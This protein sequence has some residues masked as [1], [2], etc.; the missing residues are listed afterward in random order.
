M[1]NVLAPSSEIPS[2]V[3]ILVALVQ[4]LALLLLHQSTELQFWPHNELQW[5]FSFYSIS[6]VTPT[7]LLLGLSCGSEKTVYKWTFIFSLAVLATGFYIG[8]QAVPMEHVRY[9]ELLFIFVLTLLV[10]TFKGLMYVQHFATGA[11]L[12]YSRLF[13]LSW[14]NFLT[15]ALSLLFTLCFW[16][17]L[18]LWA[19]LFKAIKIDFFFDLFMERWFFYPALALANGFGVIIFRQQSNIIDTITRIQQALMKFLLV[20]LVFVSLIFLVTL[21]FTGLE[22]LWETGGSMLIL[23]MQALMLFFLNAVYQ[24]D[25]ESNP[26]PLAVHRFIYLGI[27]LLPIYSSISFYGLSLRVEQYGWSISRSWAFLLWTVFALF[28]LGYL[29]GILK[30]KDRWLHQLSWVNVR[31]GLVVLAL[32]FLVNTPVLDFRKLSLNSQLARLDSGVVSADEFD[33]SYLRNDLAKPGYVALEALK[34]KHGSSNPEIVVLINSLYANRATDGIGSSEE[35]LLSAIE[36]IGGELP[37]GLGSAVYS[38]L[39]DNPWRLNQNHGYYIFSVDLNDDSSQ[40]YVLLEERKGW[41]QLTL[42][43]RD[44]DAW[45]NANMS[46]QGGFEGLSEEVLSAIKKA[47]FEIRKSHWND[48]E[49][50]GVI[51]KVRQ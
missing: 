13:Q 23:W 38:L 39:S 42:F 34:E 26:Y 8:N 1:G 4:G 10:T 18:M 29:C 46:S 17:V 51:F 25:P 20:I 9:S 22:P 48:I 21:P 12:S 24:D 5:L 40:E 50:G 44:D 37:D 45:A 19:A 41:H 30:L 32:M 36:V 11:V 43:Y 16:G 2:K 15:L 28:S 31:M 27:A 3:L 6:A 47:E 33:Y 49:I 7:M 35:V 14:R